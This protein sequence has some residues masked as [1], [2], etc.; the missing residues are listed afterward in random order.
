MLGADVTAPPA[1]YGHG[2]SGGNQ[3]NAAG[4]PQPWPGTVE[5]IRDIEENIWSPRLGIKG[6]VDITVEVK[7]HKRD[8]QVPTVACSGGLSTT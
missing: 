4:P 6:K 1:A 3:R 8:K 7:L 2:T 5:T